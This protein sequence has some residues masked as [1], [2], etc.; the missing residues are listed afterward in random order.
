MSHISER[1]ALGI[2]ES[3]STNLAFIMKKWKGPF[4]AAVL[5]F[6]FGIA[7]AASSEESDLDYIGDMIDA[8]VKELEEFW[9]TETLRQK[10]AHVYGFFDEFVPQKLVLHKKVDTSGDI[11]DLINAITDLTGAVKYSPE[12]LEKEL[13]EITFDDEY[14]RNDEWLPPSEDLG[15]SFIKLSLTAQCIAQKSTALI[16][17]EISSYFISQQLWPNQART[18]P[19]DTQIQEALRTYNKAIADLANLLGCSAVVGKHVDDPIKAF[20]YKQVQVY[21]DAMGEAQRKYKDQGLD[22]PSL[23][24]IYDKIMGEAE[25][26]SKGFD[27]NVNLRFVLSLKLDRLKALTPVHR[28][29]TGWVYRDVYRGREYRCEIGS[30]GSESAARDKVYSDW[31]A[32]FDSVRAELMSPPAEDLGLISEFVKAYA[33]RMSDLVSSKTVNNAGWPELEAYHSLVTQQFDPKSSIREYARQYGWCQAIERLIL[34]RQINRLKAISPVYR[35]TWG[36]HQA[37]WAFEDKYPAPF[38]Y[39]MDDKVEATSYYVDSP[40]FDYKTTEFYDDVANHWQS[41]LLDVLKELTGLQADGQPPFAKEAKILQG[42]SDGVKSLLEQLL[43]NPPEMEMKIPDDGWSD[44]PLPV[45]SP[46]LSAVGVQ[47]AFSYVNANGT[48]ARSA[49]SAGYTLTDR[50][51]AQLWKP[52]LHGIPVP[53]AAEK[54]LEILVWRQFILRGQGRR[55]DDDVPTV[56][57]TLNPGTT[58]YT[59]ADDGVSAHA[60]ETPSNQD[61]RLAHAEKTASSQNHRPASPPPVSRPTDDVEPDII[62]K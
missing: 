16:A 25:E 14:M 19:Q 6:I 24:V 58:Q 3:V 54:V 43:P 34:L 28:D 50:E 57:A 8:A 7:C 46:W 22:W 61:Q 48:G 59:D 23:T 4:G 60:V 17:Q 44:D 9:K 27:F 55:V 45:N 5:S 52:T 33:R 40:I 36:E 56:V 26:A 20:V 1:A 53:D 30:G 41:H 31:K 35:C 32:N 49:W 18:V 2:A 62:V 10:I 39:R 12:S 21:A 38:Q 13:V 51:K 42:W 37:A 15:L 47:Y 29:A 11:K